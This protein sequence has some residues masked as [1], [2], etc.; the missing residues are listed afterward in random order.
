[1]PDS[2][3]ARNKL[4]CTLQT[5]D[6]KKNWCRLLHTVA[7]RR[8]EL[9][10]VQPRSE[11]WCK[12][13][14]TLS[15]LHGS[16]KTLCLPRSAVSRKLA[17]RLKPARIAS[18]STACSLTNVTDRPWEKKNRDPRNVLKAIMLVDWIEMI[19]LTAVL[20]CPFYRPLLSGE[21]PPQ[22]T[23]SS[24]LSFKFLNKNK[25]RKKTPEKR[26]VRRWS[27]YLITNDIRTLSFCIPFPSH[28]EFS[29]RTLARRGWW[30][31]LPSEPRHRK[32]HLRQDNV[33]RTCY[34]PAMAKANYEVYYAP[35]S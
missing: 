22:E 11:S 24:D 7:P 1:M 18:R 32:H 5:P 2:G 31:Q 8:R 17:K 15:C 12:T 27:V 33:T 14:E 26:R 13:S 10:S 3:I 29:W 19:T 23:W 4:H 6:T 9:F 20:L 25:K 28:R 34:V 16:R 35:P 21:T 30:R